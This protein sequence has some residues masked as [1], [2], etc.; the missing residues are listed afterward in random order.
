MS[1]HD[2][3]RPRFGEPVGP[4]FHWFAWR[5]VETVDRGRCFLRPVWRRRIQKHSFLTGGADFW[6]QHAVDPTPEE[7]R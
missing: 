2:P 4:W 6:F 7:Q 5:P 3:Y 1:E